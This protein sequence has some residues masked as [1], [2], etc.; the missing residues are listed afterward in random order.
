MRIA[1]SEYFKTMAL[2]NKI[3][4]QMNQSGSGSAP[5]TDPLLGAGSSDPLLDA[6]SSG[7]TPSVSDSNN[8]QAT[9]D[10][11]RKHSLPGAS[12]S[13]P[14]ARGTAAQ[15]SSAHRHAGRIHEIV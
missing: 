8:G 11:R 5:A 3:D 6:G 13:N 12:E 10:V 7:A 4:G 2:V 9:R 15:P 1:G 14:Q